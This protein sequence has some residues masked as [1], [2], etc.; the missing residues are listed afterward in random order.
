[1]IWSGLGLTCSNIAFIS[2]YTR[3]QRLLYT[4]RARPQDAE[5][6]PQQGRPTGSRRALPTANENLI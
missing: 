4:H 6:Q 2:K 5:A 3:H 1:M